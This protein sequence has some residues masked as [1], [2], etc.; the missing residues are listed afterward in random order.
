MQSI[1]PL[2]SQLWK[3]TELVSVTIDYFCL[4]IV[5]V[6]GINT[7]C[8]F[9]CSIPLLST[10]F[11][12]FI[13][14][15]VYNTCLFFLLLSIIP[16]YGYT[17]VCSNFYNFVHGERY[18]SKFMPPAYEYPIVP[19]AFVEDCPFSTELPLPIC[20]KSIEHVSVGL[21]LY[22]QFWSSSLS[23]QYHTVFKLW[24]YNEYRIR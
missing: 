10:M 3:I 23:I 12:R 21:L 18:G 6:N 8:T 4:C 9:L 11:S 15:D 22:N 13:C 16:L 24:L 7:V 2:Y 1:F 5:Y 14:I 17:T 20:Q 19:A